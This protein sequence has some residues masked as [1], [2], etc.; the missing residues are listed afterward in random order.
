MFKI[1]TV[2]AF[3]E[4]R[5]TALYDV[6]YKIFIIAMYVRTF[7]CYNIDTFLRQS[8]LDRFLL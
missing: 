3:F 4:S 6:V 5:L 8:A 7:Y 1:L 2:Q